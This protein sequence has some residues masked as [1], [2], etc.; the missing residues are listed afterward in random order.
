LIAGLDA[1]AM[2]PAGLHCLDLGASTG[3]F[4]QVLLARGAAHVV[5]VDVGHGQLHA[6][7]AADPRVTAIEGLNVR[8]LTAADLADAPQ[9]V[10]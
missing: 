9:F 1:F 7:L 10:T 6:S 3:G 5:A 8:D 4:T 2:S